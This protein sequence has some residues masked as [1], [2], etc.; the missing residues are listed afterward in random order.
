MSLFRPE[1][2]EAIRRWREVLAGTVVMALG[3][4]WALT[5]FG[6]LFLIGCGLFLGGAA[7]I[8]SGVQRGRFRQ[9]GGGAGVVD[10]DERQITYFGPFGG[11]AMAVGEIVELGTDGAG[12]W[13]L[14]DVEGRSLSIPMRAEGAEALFDAF[15]A[16]PGMTGG[17]LVEASQSRAKGYTRVWVNAQSR[18]R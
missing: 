3:L 1:A 9:G 11:G 18:L 8:I 14:R 17:A 12:T 15:S 6:A 13:L 2:M 10:V 16:L 4:N 7:L 5:G